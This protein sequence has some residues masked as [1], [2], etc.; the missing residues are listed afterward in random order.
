MH[1]RVVYRKLTVK[2]GT[3]PKKLENLSESI[4]ADVTS[5]FRSFL[6]DTTW[7]EYT[8]HTTH[9]TVSLVYIHIHMY[10]SP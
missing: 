3:F 2:T 5:S 8:T 1:A 9:Y 7:R 4:V 6:R 10:Q